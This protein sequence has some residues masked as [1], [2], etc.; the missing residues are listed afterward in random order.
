MKK[1]DLKDMLEGKVN[2]EGA[3]NSGKSVWL[4]GQEMERIILVILL[5]KGNVGEIILFCK[6]VYN[7]NSTK[8]DLFAS[9]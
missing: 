3:G 1:R 7:T 9:Q 6:F 8:E 2:E 5:P 4:S